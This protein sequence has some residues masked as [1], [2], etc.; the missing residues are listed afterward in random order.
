MKIWFVPV[1]INPEEREKIWFLWLLNYNLLILCKIWLYIFYRDS[2]SD[3]EQSRWKCLKIPHYS[4]SNTELFCI[5]S[6][7]LPNVCIVQCVSHLTVRSLNSERN[8]CKAVSFSRSRWSLIMIRSNHICIA[9][10][11]KRFH[12]W[13]LF[14]VKLHWR[15]LLK[16]C[17][18]SLSWS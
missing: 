9:I 5:P 18:A 2:V 16:K 6:F 4:I 13:R 3:T 8:F 1:A 15:Q 10:E 12:L 11:F 7:Q 17:F 14:V